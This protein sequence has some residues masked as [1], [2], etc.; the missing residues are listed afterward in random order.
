MKKRLPLG[1][2]QIRELYT[3]KE[4]WLAK[5]GHWDE[6]LEIYDLKLSQNPRDAKAVAGKIK[7]LGNTFYFILFG[8]FI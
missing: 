1:E 2:I 6:A 8:H 7:C 5:L 4:S 3:V